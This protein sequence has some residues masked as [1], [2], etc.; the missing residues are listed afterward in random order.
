M[1]GSAS[2][3]TRER[4][5]FQL[6][7]EPERI[8]VESGQKAEVKLRLVRHWPDFKNAVNY[9]PLNFPGQFQLGNGT[10]AADQTEVTLTIAVQAGTRAADYTLAVLGQ[11]QVPFNK[12]AT[13]PEKPNTLVSIPSRPLTITVT[14]PPK[15]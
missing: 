11:G 12:D 3:R 15:K 4:S 9:Q 6:T 1:T 8:T 13:K 2:L 10:I 14:E 5:P 7:I